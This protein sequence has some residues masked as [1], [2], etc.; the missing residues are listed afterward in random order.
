VSRANPYIQTLIRQLGSWNVEVRTNAIEALARL[1]SPAIPSLSQAL[2]YPEPEIREYAA[3]ALGRIGGSQVIRVLIDTLEQNEPKLTA[4]AT[5]ALCRYGKPTLEPLLEAM[6]EGSLDLRIHALAI[7]GRIDLPEAL[8][9]LLVAVDD[10]EF[11]MRRAAV[12]ALEN[13]QGEVVVSALC[14]A[15]M[16]RGSGVRARAAEILC[17]RAEK[18]ALP[19][20]LNSLKDE[21]SEVRAYTAEALGYFEAEEVL[22]SLIEALKEPD[23]Y[24]RSQIVKSL[25]RLDPTRTNWMLCEIITRDT[26]LSIREIVGDHW[27]THAEQDAVPTLITVLENDLPTMRS[28]AVVALG[29]LRATQAVP[30]LVLALRQGVAGSFVLSDIVEALAKIGT[31]AI[32]EI[33]SFLPEPS[34]E[35]RSRLLGALDAMD[36]PLVLPRRVLANKN[37]TTEQ[38]YKTLVTLSQIRKGIGY[39]YPIGDVERYCEAI[40]NDE[41]LDRFLR[42]GAEEVLHAFTYLRASSAPDQADTLLRPATELVDTKARKELLRAAEPAPETLPQKGLRSRIQKFFGRTD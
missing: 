42:S 27:V 1:G 23:V 3:E 38:K 40:A 35:V 10:V 17:H 37:L 39:A 41:A 7:L 6:K 24:V 19:Y 16:D 8:P 4:R 15:L 33:C 9:P 34:F 28:Y 14:K 26:S 18:Q 13:K 31:P 21:N 20:L 2:H 5:E 22:A 29:R 32:P 12:L 25:C 30:A 11:D 36:T